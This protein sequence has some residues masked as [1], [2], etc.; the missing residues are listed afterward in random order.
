MKKLIV[1]LFVLIIALPTTIYAS[2]EFPKK[3]IRVYVSYGAGGSTDVTMR[4][5]ARILER[6]KEFSLNI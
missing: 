4:F 6:P 3:P 1:L 2:G 5:L